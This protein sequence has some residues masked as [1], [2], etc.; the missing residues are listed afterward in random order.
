MNRNNSWTIAGSALVI[1]ATTGCHATMA[2]SSS[3][4]PSSALPEGHYT[5]VGAEWPLKFRA[6]YFGAHCF[7]T[8]SCEILYRGFRHGA[9]DRPS[10]SVESYGRPLDKLLSAG[11]GPIPNFPSPA[12]VTWRSKDGTPLEAEIDIGEIFRDELIR[13][14]LKEDEVSE[15]G[16][17]PGSLPAIIL[18]VND[19]AISVYMRAHISTRQLQTPG[20]RHSD[21]R[22]DLIK[23][24]SRN[25]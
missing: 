25:Y 24:F 17:G 9:E 14:N 8:Q 10:P 4:S 20:N 7:D 5:N 12:R 22:N 6:H 16:P 21:F 11:R 15:R 19:R 3:D 13:H 18:E 2:Q 23:V 1:I